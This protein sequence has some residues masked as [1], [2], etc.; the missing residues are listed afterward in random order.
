[1]GKLVPATTPLGARIDVPVEKRTA[2]EHLKALC[3]AVSSATGA[4]VRPNG[5]RFDHAF[6]ANG[7]LLPRMSTGAERPYMLFEWGANGTTAREALID[8]LGRSATRMTWRIN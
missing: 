2:S 5:G 4:T 3:D 6:A 1:M 7:Y 8:L